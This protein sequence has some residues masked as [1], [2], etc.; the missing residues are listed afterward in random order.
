MKKVAESLGYHP[1]PELSR[2]MT[3]LRKHREAR[4][5]ST[6]GLLT[7]HRD[8]SLWK[9]NSFLRRLHGSIAGR[10]EELGYRTEDF[11]LMDGEVSPTR[12]RNILVA[13]GVKALILVDGPVRM[14]TIDF[15]FSPFATVTIGYGVGVPLHRVCQHQYQEMFQLLRHLRELGY[16]NPG[17]VLEKE[18][19]ERTQFHYSSAF[20]I[21]RD[22]GLS[23]GV[24]VLVQ[25]EITAQ[26]FSAWFKRHKPDVVIAQ[27]PTAATYVSW[28]RALKQRVPDDVGFAALDV[29]IDVKPLCSGIVQNYEGVASAAVELVVSE[30]RCGER[31]VPTPPKVLLIEGK[32]YD[33]GT[34]RA[35]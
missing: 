14:E 13:R 32:W 18:T 7:L 34:T 15:D 11:V 21:A 19:N 5:V 1:D 28:L 30:V 12:L 16:T 29:D 9:V 23:S 35:K 2:L 26:E 27:S 17:L 4:S 24:P 25:K 31:G 10:A 22:Q 33:G 20:T 3:Y 6:L 8:P